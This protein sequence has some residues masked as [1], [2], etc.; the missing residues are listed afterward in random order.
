MTPTEREEMILKYTPR[1]Q[2]VG[3]RI[4]RKWGA[5]PEDCAQTAVVGLIEAIDSWDPAGKT[6]RFWTYAYR[7]V[8]RTVYRSRGWLP[9]TIDPTTRTEKELKKGIHAVKEGIV[10][11][12]RV[13]ELDDPDDA[14]VRH[15]APLCSDDPE[16]NTLLLEL[17]QFAARDLTPREQYV[18]S[19]YLQGDG[20]DGA[21]VAGEMGVSRARYNQIKSKALKKLR[22]FLGGE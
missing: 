10:P 22:A 11:P 16:H 4:A 13:I 3:R 17:V 6:C 9:L 7:I 21:L 20:R 8:S 18:L 2:S 1:A 5:D 12:T 15:S 19:T 14:G